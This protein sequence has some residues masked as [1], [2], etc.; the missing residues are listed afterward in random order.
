[1]IFSNFNFFKLHAKLVKS[2]F[3]QNF[4]RKRQRICPLRCIEVARHSLSWSIPPKF[5]HKLLRYKQ[6]FG[7]LAATGV[8]K[9]N[10]LYLIQLW[11]Q[12]FQTFAYGEVVYAQTW[13]VY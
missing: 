7:K 12:V 4:L 13:K 8:K 5:E 11:W 6:G 9:P 3:K 10:H 1:M 2:Q